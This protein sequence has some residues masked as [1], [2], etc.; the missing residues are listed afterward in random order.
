MHERLDELGVATELPE[1]SDED[2]MVPRGIMQHP[3]RIYE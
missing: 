1:I 3:E 2:L